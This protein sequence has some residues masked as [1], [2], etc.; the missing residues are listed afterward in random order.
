MDNGSTDGTVE[1]LKNYD[2]VSVLRMGLPYINPK[3][4]RGGT[5]SLFK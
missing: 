1:A 2:N 4:G 5:K 3:G